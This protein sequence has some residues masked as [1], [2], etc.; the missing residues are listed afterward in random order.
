MKDYICYF[1]YEIKGYSNVN[2]NQ[3]YIQ[4][5]LSV[6]LLLVNLLFCLSLSS[7]RFYGEVWK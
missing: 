6:I 1:V 7:Y 3:A 4:V 5:P 2:Y